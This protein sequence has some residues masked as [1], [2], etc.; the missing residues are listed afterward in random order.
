[1]KRFCVIFAALLTAAGVSAA[2]Y[3]GYLYPAG[4]RA[5]TTVRVLVGGQQL[6]GIVGATV[7]G[8]GVRVVKAVNV[9]NFPFPDGKQRKWL[10]EWLKNLEKGSTEKPPLPDNVDEWR[11]C[12]WW[13]KLDQLD[14]LERTLV[15]YNLYVRQNALQQTPSL[16]QMAI[17][18]I[19]ADADAPPGEREL[20]I[21]CRSGVSAPKLFYID[22]APHFSEPLYTRPGLK[23]PPMPH[24]KEL[25]AVLDG[26]IM[27]GETDS[28]KL[29]LQPDTEYTFTLTGWKLLPFIGDAVPGHFQPVLELIGPDGK[30]A[31]FADDEYFLPDPVMRFRS[32]PG[33]DYI[34]KVR[35]NLYR[36]RQDFV[37]R[38]TLDP[39]TEPFRMTGCSFP[40][41]DEFPEEDYDNRVLNVRRP[42]VIP[43]KLAKPGECDVYRFRGGKGMVFT[44]CLAARRD[45]SPLD[46]VLTLLG[47]DGK[48]IMQVD[49]TPRAVN[50]GAIPQ[51][52]DPDLRVEL[53]ADGIYTVKVADLNK[54]GGED[55]RYRLRLGPEEPDFNVYTTNSMVSMHPGQSAPVKLLI[56]RLGG[57]AG[58]ITIAADNDAV[59]VA[60]VIP[61]KAVEYTLALRN[62]ARKAVPPRSVEIYAE[63]KINGRTVRKKVVSA[64]IF[65]QAF[66]YDHLLPARDFCIGTRTDGRARPKPPAAAPAKKPDGPQPPAAGGRGRPA[67]HGRLGR[68]RPG[69][70]RPGCHPDD[71]RE[72]WRLCAE[73]DPVRSD[74]AG[75]LC[76]PP[77]IR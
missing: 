50:V 33:G 1:M 36:G 22:A 39:G 38:V 57:F 15:T 6:Y 63:A 11:K 47:P 24:V 28:F 10:Q 21:V 30:E 19:E 54:A 9:P 56:E 72:Y 48:E 7:S 52:T 58:P 40:D 51:Q 62:S 32:G 20:R 45:G 65:N 55:Y 43:G 69:L 70:D 26:Q 67:A 18:D 31:A 64:D 12:P 66:A 17:L 25:P 75:A 16:R 2:P 35:D 42:L 59:P 34:L 37:Y 8:K 71:F 27:P 53:P 77:G 60:R 76:T 61:E 29:T 3:A 73:S 4:M 49:D 44:A 13:D 5:G 46:G 68:Y 23:K 14:P 41:L 74:P